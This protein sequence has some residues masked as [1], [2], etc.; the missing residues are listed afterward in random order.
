[1]GRA[2]EQLRPVSSSY[3]HRA[4]LSSGGSAK[5]SARTHQDEV[6]FRMEAQ[7]MRGQLHQRIS[8][9]PLRRTVEDVLFNGRQGRVAVSARGALSLRSRPKARRSSERRTFS[10]GVAQQ[11]GGGDFCIAWNSFESRLRAAGDAIFKGKGEGRRGERRGRGRASRAGR[12]GRG[13]AVPPQ[14]EFVRLRR[15][16]QLLPL[17]ASPAPFLPS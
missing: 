7:H 3:R 4:R 6:P 13:R 11:K 2:A 10:S 17:N 15:R 14:L 16:R 8:F 12:T 5:H 1:V 9:A